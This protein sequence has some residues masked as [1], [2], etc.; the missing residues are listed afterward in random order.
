M[1]ENQAEPTSLPHPQ[2]IV[3]FGATGATGTEVV[4]Q[5]LRQG[6]TVVAVVR[7][8]EALPARDGLIVL[9]GNGRDAASIEAA[10]V[11][12]DTVISCIG[13][14]KNR[15]PGVIMSVGTQN[16]VAGCERAKVRRFVMQSGILQSP[17]TELSVGNRLFLRLVRLFLNAVYTD[18]IKAEATVQNSKTGWVIVRAVGLEHAPARNTYTAGPG[19]AV[20]PFQSLTFVDCAACLLRATYEPQ[21][22]HKAINVGR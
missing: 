8:P 11:G 18:K 3:V 17:G 14:T 6:H 16:I 15:Q 21:W 19:V 7:R 2:R 5:A 22:E 12:A 9:P 1:T 13:P 20:S 10:F 4:N